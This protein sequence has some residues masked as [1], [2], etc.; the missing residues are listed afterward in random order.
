MI[1]NLDKLGRLCIP[2]EMRKQHEWTETTPLLMTLTSQGVLITE[3]ASRCSICGGSELLVEINSTNKVCMDCI[4][5]I[6]NI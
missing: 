1:R 3:Q 5:K 2:V 4:N 6:K